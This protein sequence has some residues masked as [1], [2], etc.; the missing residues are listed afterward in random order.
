MQE[1]DR[2]DESGRLEEFEIEHRIETRDDRNE[3]E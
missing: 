1:Q 2:P 3:P